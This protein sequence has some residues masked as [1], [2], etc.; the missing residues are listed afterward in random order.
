MH[1]ILFFQFWKKPRPKYSETTSELVK[2][3][4]TLVIQRRHVQASRQ[5]ILRIVH[6]LGLYHF[7]SPL[8]GTCITPTFTYRIWGN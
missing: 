2:K 8:T 7:W 3:L 6:Y 5:R 1:A 4:N